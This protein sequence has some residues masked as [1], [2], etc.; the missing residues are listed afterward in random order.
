MFSRK[1]F[2]L[3]PLE[4][5]R[6]SAGTSNVMFVDKGCEEK[7][8]LRRRLNQQTSNEDFNVVSCFASNDTSTNRPRSVNTFDG[9]EQRTSTIEW[10]DDDR[11]TFKNFLSLVR[12]QCSMFQVFR[13]QTRNSRL[14]SSSVEFYIR[15]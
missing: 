6:T 10:L 4:P 5:F 12:R 1:S 7:Q 13:Q 2:E 14:S 11:T 8:T 15:F 3:K 9:S